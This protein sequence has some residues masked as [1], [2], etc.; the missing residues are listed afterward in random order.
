M[1]TTD[2]LDKTLSLIGQVATEI[3]GD[4]QKIVEG[5]DNVS[6]TLDDI[7]GELE[8]GGG[9]AGG[10]AGGGRKG[11]GTAGRGGRP[12]TAKQGKKDDSIGGVESILAGIKKHPVAALAAAGAAIAGPILGAGQVSA[13]RGGTREG[14][15]SA[16][17]NRMVASIP[18][19][20]AS[21][22]VAQE[23]TIR[24]RE[25]AR[26]QQVL[27]EVAALGGDVT[28]EMR[29][30]TFDQIHG[31][32]VRRQ[33]EQERS[34]RYME[35]QWLKQGPLGDDLI[36]KRLKTARDAFNLVTGNITEFFV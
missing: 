33:Q 6:S 1:A 3:G 8:K 10:G 19:L 9:G 2:D 15:E 11:G 5:L 25:S 13:M 14:G 35:Q 30:F 17:I 34:L 24:G 27:G 32:E 29:Q 28:P 20:G 36:Q 16:Q 12:S 23:Q 7:L 18:V 22:G 26:M 4:T 21:T 31:Q